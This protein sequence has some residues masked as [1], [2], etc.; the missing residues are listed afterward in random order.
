MNHSQANN[1]YIAGV[2]FLMMLALATA[3]LPELALSAYLEVPGRKYLA[4]GLFLFGSLCGCWAFFRAS[5]RTSRPWQV[6]QAQVTLPYLL[7]FLTTFV[8]IAV[9]R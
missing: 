8:A 1:V 6:P 9:S 3:H 4:A 5:A 2:G 7:F